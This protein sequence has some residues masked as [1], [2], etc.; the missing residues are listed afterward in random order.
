VKKFVGVAI[1]LEQL[2]PK[3]GI[4]GVGVSHD[5]LTR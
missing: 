2:L 4:R 5:S 1:L 3:A